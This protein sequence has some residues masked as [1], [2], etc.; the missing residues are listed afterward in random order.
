MKDLLPVTTHDAQRP[1]CL[2][3]IQLIVAA[4]KRLQI[5]EQRPAFVPDGNDV[6]PNV[7]S[8][9]C[10]HVNNAIHGGKQGGGLSGNNFL[11]RV[12]RFH[13]KAIKAFLF[14]YLTDI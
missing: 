10:D 13:K 14:I 3:P 8:R 6:N 11:P 1:F 2:E 7:T 9:N 12:N 5:C 4:N